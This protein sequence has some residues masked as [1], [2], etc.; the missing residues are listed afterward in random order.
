MSEHSATI[1]W[2]RTSD[3]FGYDNFNRDHELDFGHGLVVPASSAPDYPVS[4]ERVD[5]E[6]SY[7]AAVDIEL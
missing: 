5:P 4:A 6:Q 3:D 1:R 7:V 2:Q